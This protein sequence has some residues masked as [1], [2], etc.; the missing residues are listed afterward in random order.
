[1]KTSAFQDILMKYM[2]PVAHKVEQNNYLSAVKDG[3]IASVPIIIVGSFSTLPMALGNLFASGAIHEF[4][5]A[6]TPIVGYI[7]KFT[8]DILSIYAAFFI[9]V[10]LAKRFGIHNTQ[11][12]MTAIMVHI[13]LCG[14]SIE[15]G[16]GL[17]YLGASGLF[18][19]IISGIL[20][21]EITRFLWQSAASRS[22]L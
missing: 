15:G 8:T 3:M 7:G 4:F 16:L 18:T 10:A 20:S 14:V 12:G 1:M 6:I 5:A 9:A 13:I 2:M 22:R 11:T 21:V 17:D 19:S